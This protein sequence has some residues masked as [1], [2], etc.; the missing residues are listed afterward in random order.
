MTNSNITTKEVY[1]A[2]ITFDAPMEGTV[3]VAAN[4]EEHARKII[5]EMYAKRS[6]LKIV[7]IYNIVNSPEM[8]KAYDAQSQASKAQ[9]KSSLII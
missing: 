4:D 7:D 6:N 5:E 3:T 8:K 1:N 2:V 9:A